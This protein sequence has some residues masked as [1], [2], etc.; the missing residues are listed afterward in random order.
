MELQTTVTDADKVD[1][2]SGKK[3]LFS[4]PV[5]NLGFEIPHFCKIG[6]TLG[7]QIGFSTVFFGSSTTVLG[8]TSSLPDDAVAFIDLKHHDKSSFTGFE[9]AAFKP[10]ADITAFSSN[11]K[12]AVFT[13]ADIMFGIDFDKIEKMDVE[14]NLKLPQLS[15]TLSAGY[16]K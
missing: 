13:Q 10:I 1:Q 15:T 3:D 5:P 8:A 7:Y 2:L 12:L 6:L 11:L 14:L 4:M 9:G 16:R